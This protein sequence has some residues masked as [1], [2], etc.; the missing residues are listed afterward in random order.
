LS[1]TL[2]KKS[3]KNINM[4]NASDSD[5]T[6]PTKQDDIGL[7]QF[8]ADVLE[9]MLGVVRSRKSKQT[10]GNDPNSKHI[11]ATP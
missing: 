3:P 7:S 11:I 6:D 1:A 9:F 8:S 10:K 5:I 4:G 2:L